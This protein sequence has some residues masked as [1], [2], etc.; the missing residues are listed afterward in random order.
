MTQAAFYCFNNLCLIDSP[1]DEDGY[2]VIVAGVFLCTC[3]TLLGLYF[4]FSK[5]QDNLHQNTT[6][7]RTKERQQSLTKRDTNPI[8]LILIVVGIAGDIFFINR[9]N[10][11]QKPETVEENPAETMHDEQEIIQEYTD[12]GEKEDVYTVVEQMPE[13]P[14]GES[15]LVKYLSRIEYPSEA[16]ENDIE[17]SVY[18]RFVVGKSGEV[19]DVEIAKGSNLLLNNAALRHVKEMP[20]WKPGKQNGKEVNVQYIVPIKFV[21]Q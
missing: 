5:R 11:S 13:F 3:V 20:S 9:Y 10:Q 6:T 7:G 17:G 14:G 4:L 16:K 1:P 12:Q 18:I 2:G 15:A 19:K 21:L 8:W